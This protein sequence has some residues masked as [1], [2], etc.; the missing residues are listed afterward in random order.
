MN[1]CTYAPSGQFK[2]NFTSS[3]EIIRP[4]SPSAA[5]MPTTG[6][7]GLPG[8]CESCI[9][10]Q[11]DNIFDDYNWQYAN[12]DAVKAAAQRYAASVP[13]PSTADSSAYPPECCPIIPCANT[14]PSSRG[15]LTGHSATNGAPAYSGCTTTLSFSLNTDNP[16]SIGSGAQPWVPPSNARPCNWVELEFDKTVYMSRTASPGCG[17]SVSLTTMYRAY[18]NKGSETAYVLGNVTINGSAAFYTDYSP[19]YTPPLS[20]ML[21]R[22]FY[23]GHVGDAPNYSPVAEEDYQY[24]SL[25][26]TPYRIRFGTYFSAWSGYDLNKQGENWVSAEM[27]VSAIPVTLIV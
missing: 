10:V 16:W 22:I 12:I 3:S 13:A 6:S 17:G 20:N 24:I 5:S 19:G 25:S 1:N 23:I 27:G 2:V 4:T 9:E 21:N 7:W 18:K 15:T 26:Q 11:I 14:S 8:G